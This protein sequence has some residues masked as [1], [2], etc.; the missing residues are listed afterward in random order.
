MERWLRSGCG[1]AWKKASPEYLLA[2]RLF[3]SLGLWG[4]MTLFAG[5]TDVAGRNLLFGLKFFQT[6]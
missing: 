3:P 6:N 2:A 1:E 5:K 4:R